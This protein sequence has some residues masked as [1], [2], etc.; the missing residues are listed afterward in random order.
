MYGFRLASC[1]LVGLVLAGPAAAQ[2]PRRDSAIPLSFAPLVEHAN[3]AVVNIYTRKFVRHQRTSSFFEE[4]ILRRLF[5]ENLPRVGDHKRVETSLGSGVIVAREGVIVTNSHVV[6][7][8]ED[9]VVI[10][11]DRRR[12]AARL[13]LAD[14][15]T[16]LAVL[17]IDPQ[18]ESMA[19]LEFAEMAELR[20]GDLVLAI[21]NPFGVGQSVTGGIVSALAR[22][23]VGIADFNFFIQTEA[24]I[25]PGNSGGGLIDVN[26]RLVGINTAIYSRTSESVGIGYAIPASMVRAIVKTALSGRPLVRPWIGASGRALPP[27][28]AAM[29]GFRR[30]FGALILHVQP[31][32]PFAAAGG[33]PGDVVLA[34]DGR[35]IED[36]EALRFR[37]AVRDIGTTTRIA[38]RRG[39]HGGEIDVTIAAPL[40]TPP[41]D[42][43][44]LRG[45]HPPVG[46]ARGQP[47]AG[48]GRT[49]GRR[50]RGLRRARARPRARLGGAPQRAAPR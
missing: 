7:G 5:G 14:P 35:E 47:L 28:L 50:F 4:P 45:Y 44:R 22:T 29:L 8:A 42:E 12:Y 41:F 15:Q 34:I 37:I 16:D 48:A 25:N 30:P 43:R 13:V 31:D 46:R 33:R 36:A 49:R 24:A 40:E 2:E 17:A 9:I 20:V 32:G 26:G 23:A 19:F 18:D 21:G 3:S 39:S 6:A 1:V 10:L 11:S 27:E 38:L